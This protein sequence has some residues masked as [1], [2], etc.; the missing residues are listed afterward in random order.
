MRVTFVTGPAVAFANASVFWVLA[1]AAH[2]R[3]IVDAKIL[4]FGV[5]ALLY[6]HDNTVAVPLGKCGSRNKCVTGFLEIERGFAGRGFRDDLDDLLS[7][8][9]RIHALVVEG[10]TS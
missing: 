1:L 6:L 8:S 2:L 4:R 10:Y 9:D 5:T 7:G 3:V